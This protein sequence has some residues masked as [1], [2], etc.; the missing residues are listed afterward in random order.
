[1]YPNRNLFILHSPFLSA[2]FLAFYYIILILTEKNEGR[3]IS[4][5]LSIAA[6]SQMGS[7]RQ[8]CP[9]QGR[10]PL[11]RKQVRQR[12]LFIYVQTA[13][14]LPAA[15]YASVFDKYFFAHSLWA[16]FAHPSMSVLPVNSLPWPA[17]RFPC[18]DE[19]RFAAG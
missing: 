14:H 7:A 9:A 5:P 3:N 13:A 2:V 15:Q 1:M 11:C 8:K 19:T 18:N 17:G 12:H 10:C 4:G 6:F 16:P